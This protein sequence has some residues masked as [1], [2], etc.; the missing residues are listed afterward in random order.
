MMNPDDTDL[1]ARMRRLRDAIRHH[2]EL[3]YRHAQ[4]EI[5]DVDYDRMKAELARLEAENPLFAEAGSPTTTV[6]DDRVDAFVKRSHLVPM[7]SLDNTYSREELEAF[8]QGLEKTF[9]QSAPLDFRVEPKIDGVAISLVYEHGVLVRAVTRG[10]GVE[11]DEITHNLGCVENLPRRLSGAKMPELVEVRGELFMTFDEFTRVNQA[12]EEEGGKPFANPRNLAAGTV[13]LLVCPRDRKLRCVCYA[14]G[15]C[16]PNPFATQSELVAALA[17]WGLPTTEISASAA[18]FEGV[19]TQIGKIDHSRHALPY[20]T[21]G[22]VVKLE[23]IALQKEAETTSKSPR[24]AIAYK[25]AAERVRTRLLAITLQVGRTGVVTPVAELEPVQVSGT[26]VSRATLHNAEELERKDLRVGDTVIIEKAG[27]IIPAVIGFVPELRPADAVPFNF[28]HT[29]PCCGTALVRNEEEV[30]WRC[31]NR[32]CPDQVRR[33]IQHY[34]SRACL[35]IQGLGEAVVD[36]I[37][38][39]GLA[40]SPADLYELQPAQLLDLEG[41]AEKSA[42]GLVTAIA[43]SR[44]AGLARVLNGLGIPQ[45][46]TTLARDLAR[47]F[48]EL[49]ALMA[50][51]AKRLTQIEGLGDTTAEAIRG[52]FADPGNARLVERLLAL[53]VGTRTPEAV[54]AIEGVAGKTFVLTGTL[55]IP[56]E[57]ARDWIEK[58]GGKVSGSVSKKTHFVVA[59]AEAGSKLDKASQLGVAVLDEAALRALLGQPAADGPAPAAD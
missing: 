48:R 4:P 9:P 28:P 36:Q 38:A 57:V 37:V 53:G 33:R 17:H 13:K 59:G 43:A 56:R 35:D 6:G 32:D 24:W 3:Y 22:A 25:F 41:F 12:R 18:G 11:G 15:A 16:R 10:N 21:D 34:A 54:S 20:P 51:D 40:S 42:Q 8:T 30:A 55:S 26:T 7:L 23:S 39:A 5:P 14:V 58:A 47:S 46:G 44:D 2:D 1:V 45:V 19:W 27:E 29:C 31:P 52:Y 50:A 49:P